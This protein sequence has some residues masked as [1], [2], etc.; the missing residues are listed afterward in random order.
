MTKIATE[1]TAHVLQAS[2]AYFGISIVT[3]LVLDTLRMRTLELWFGKL[4]AV[5]VEIPIL[6]AVCWKASLWSTRKYLMPR[7]PLLCL[8]MSLIAF[9]LFFLVEMCMSTLVI[10]LTWE[11]SLKDYVTSFLTNFPANLIGR[12]G[13]VMYGVMPL[14]QGFTEKEQSSYG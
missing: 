13:E 7:V 12:L 14:L 1:K 5:L 9:T 2:L 4:V 6:M 10:G 8:A 3:A 11:E